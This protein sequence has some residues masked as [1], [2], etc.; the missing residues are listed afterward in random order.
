[1]NL[2]SLLHNTTKTQ[3]KRVNS[4]VMEL[5]ANTTNIILLE[6]TT[7]NSVALVCERTIPSDCHLSPTLVPTFMDRG[8]HM[9]NVMDPYSRI[10]DFLDRYLNRLPNLKL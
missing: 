2:E 4:L 9:V 6:Q 3:C 8:C 1:M 10:R 5:T 7:N